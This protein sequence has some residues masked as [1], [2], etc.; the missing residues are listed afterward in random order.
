MT[1]LESKEQLC[2]KLNI[3]YDNIRAGTDGLFTWNDLDSWIN[4]ACL[5]VWDYADWTFKEK[6]YTTTTVASQEYYDY[7]GDFV[8]D[9]IY[10]LRVAGTDGL[11]D[12]YQKIRYTDFMQYRENSPT[13]QNKLWADHRRWYFINPKAFN[14]AA[15]RSIEIWG[16]LRLTELTASTT[17]LPFSPDTEGNENSGNHAIV[18]LAYAMALESE[19]KNEPQKATLI[20]NEAYQTL[21]LLADKE[22]ER[23]ADYEVYGRPFFKHTPLFDQHGGA[24]PRRSFGSDD[25]WAY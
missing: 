5:E 11:L 20:R 19:K 18:K 9:S 16:M 21:K 22:A 14:D 4:L 8:S 7:P 10:L 23:Q 6:A 17:A 24:H 15:G 3:S 25:G 13:G 1:F 12:T 2:S